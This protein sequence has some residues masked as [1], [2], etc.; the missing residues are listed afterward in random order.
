VIHLSSAPAATARRTRIPLRYIISAL[1]TLLLLYLAFRGTDFGKL[2]QTIATAN[3]WWILLSVVLLMISHAL[4]AWRWRFLMNPIKRDI[5]FRN[6]FSGVMIGYLVNNVIPR[7]GELAR[8]FVL[9]KLESLSKSAAFGT[10][11]VERII[12]IISFLV[13]V[14][15]LPV[16]YKGS[17]WTTFPWLQTASLTISLITGGGLLVLIVLMVRRDWT[18][19]LLRLIDPLLPRWVASRASNRVHSFLDGLLFL[20]N[21]GQ[22]AAILVLSVLVWWTYALM[23]YVA[24]FAFNLQGTLDFRASLVLLTISSIGVAIPTPGGTGSYHALTAQALQGLFLVDPSVALSY[25][26]IT[27]AVSYLGVTIVGSY[28]LFRD[29]VA[30]S[31]AVRTSA[32]G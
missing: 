26:T 2:L 29:N 17:L 8:P 13:L 27:H 7:G 6:L 24:F 32:G 1:A 5:G 22:S 16:L 4:R 18:D 21:P 15:L 14:M 3:Y 12:D 10:V 20:K 23:T 19:R 9:G 30:V 31:E 25:A 11:V 28:F